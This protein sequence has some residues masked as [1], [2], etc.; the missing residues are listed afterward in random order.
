[1]GKDGGRGAD[2]GAGEDKNGAGISD[3][4]GDGDFR[5]ARAPRDSGVGGGGK[6][7]DRAKPWGAGFMR[8]P[9]GH[10]TLLMWHQTRPVTTG[11]MRR[12]DCILALHRTLALASGAS[13]Y[14]W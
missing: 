11:L 4:D 1:M 8:P 12:E 14:A 7:N 2:L 6:R 5:R 13:G 3:F 10:R 9:R